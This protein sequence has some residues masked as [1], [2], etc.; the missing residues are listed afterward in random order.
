MAVNFK[1]RA[2]EALAEVPLGI[3]YFGKCYSVW[4]F[5]SL[6]LAPWLRPSIPT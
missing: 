6:A 2:P 4:F 3:A 1:Q 5:Q